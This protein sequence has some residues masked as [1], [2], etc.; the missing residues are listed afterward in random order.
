M[1]TFLAPGGPFQFQ[2]N[3]QAY[4]VVSDNV[5]GI[6][7]GGI[8]TRN[9]LCIIAPGNL[10]VAQRRLFENPDFKFGER[11][12]DPNILS[13]L[14]FGISMNER[15]G[16]I[17][18]GN[19]LIECI[20]ADRSGFGVSITGVTRISVTRLGPQELL[21]AQIQNRRIKRVAD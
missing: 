18:V 14:E 16:Q 20:T 4:V 7:G 21:K 19:D 3:G 10:L 1:R 15:R 5:Y 9:T 2:E 11:T 8:G 12:G 6:Q 17:F 13:T